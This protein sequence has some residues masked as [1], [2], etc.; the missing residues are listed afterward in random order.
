MPTERPRSEAASA[1]VYPISGQFLAQSQPLQGTPWSLT[2]FSHI[3]QIGEMSR[4][5]AAMAGVSALLLGMLGI[6]FN[7]RRR[8]L[9]ERLAA[10]EALQKAYDELERKVEERTADL[11]TRPPAGRCA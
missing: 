1:S 6:L 4:V 7:D 10:R 11:S 9:R 5:R 2:V 8:H 3:E